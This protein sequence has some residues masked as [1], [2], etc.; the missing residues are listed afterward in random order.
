[1]F[2]V[3]RN[4]GTNPHRPLLKSRIIWKVRVKA[5]YDALDPEALL[6]G[7][8]SRQSIATMPTTHKARRPLFLL[9]ALAAL[10]PCSLAQSNASPAERALLQLANQARA[11]HG[12][13][14][15]RWD[16]A[17][18]QAARAHVQWVV[19]EPGELE[20]QY[21]GEPDLLAR[22]AQ[23]KARFSTIAENIARRGQDP[24]Q[25]QQIWMSTAVHRANLLN[26]NLNAVGI[27]VVEEGGLLYAVEDFSTSV[28]SLRLSDIEAQVAQTLQS[29][30]LAPAESNQ[31]ARK[32]CAMPDGSAGSPKLVIQWDGPN[33]TELPDVLLKQIASGRYS[34]AA[35]GVCPGNQ[36]AQQFATYRVAVLLY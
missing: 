21:P 1:V 22:G 2:Q 34:S 18:A 15:L 6:L 20:H 35:V 13:P 4:N 33:P 3:Y 24:T 17:L 19:R 12:V 14:P 5:R 26:P 16:S 32:T 27:A 10:H 36:P 25:L 29:H 30:G 31:D 9:I 8:R 28:P 7:R 23:S 11:T